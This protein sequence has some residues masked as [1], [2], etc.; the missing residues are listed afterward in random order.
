LRRYISGATRSPLNDELD[1]MPADAA[2]PSALEDMQHVDEPA[3]DR[4]P[5][6]PTQ[7]YKQE[8]A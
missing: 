7:R 1:R 6:L 2:V 5:D 8:D 3:A 4:V